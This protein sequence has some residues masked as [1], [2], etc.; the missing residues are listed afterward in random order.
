MHESDA[1]CAE[2]EAQIERELAHEVLGVLVGVRERPG[3][4][5]L[6]ELAVVRC[7]V[8][9]PAVLEIAGDRVVVVAVDRRNLPLLDQHA[10]FV[11][12]RA[13]ADQ[14]AAA[15]EL[16]D[17]DRVDRVEARLERGQ[18]GVN[19]RD[20]CDPVHVGLPVGRGHGR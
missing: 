9:A 8:C 15:V 11:G 14:V 10:H 19:V 4:G 5:L 3:N 2:V 16:L 6:A 1:F 20:D 12:V 17:A 7:D 13:V 18:V